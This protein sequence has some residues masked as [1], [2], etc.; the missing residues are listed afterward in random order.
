MARIVLK[1]GRPSG[2]WPAVQEQEQ[3]QNAVAAGELEV[4]VGTR[5]AA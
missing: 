4:A 3:D 2:R 5:I 1:S